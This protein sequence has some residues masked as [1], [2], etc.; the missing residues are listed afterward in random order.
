MFED[1]GNILDADE[2]SALLAVFA[3]QFAIR[4][5]NPQGILGW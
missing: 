1:R 4:G 2:G 3:D 5:I